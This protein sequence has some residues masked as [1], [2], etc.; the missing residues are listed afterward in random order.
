MPREVPEV[1]VTDDP[2]IVLAFVA[3]FVVA[4]LVAVAL[5]ARFSLATGAVPGETAAPHVTVSAPGS[6]DRWSTSPVDPR[7][8]RHVRME[9]P[10]DD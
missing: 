1:H 8:A 9:E 6:T 5:A 7:V 2:L 4:I 3:M 10:D